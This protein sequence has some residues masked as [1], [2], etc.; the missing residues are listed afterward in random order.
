LFGVINADALD[1]GQLLVDVDS[2]IGNQVWIKLETFPFNFNFVFM[3]KLFK[4][5]LKP[6]FA[7]VAERTH[8]VAPNLYF[9]DAKLP[10]LFLGTVTAK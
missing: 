1:I 5:L 3:F 10:C 6:A 9:H 7:D 2:W 4:S 8:Y